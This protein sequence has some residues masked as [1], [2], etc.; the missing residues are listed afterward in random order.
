METKE[1]TVYKNETGENQPI[2]RDIY[3]PADKL[4]DL[5]SFAGDSSETPHPLQHVKLEVR[6]DTITAY[7]TNGHMAIRTTLPEKDINYPKMGD[8]FTKGDRMDIAISDCTVMYEF[9]KNTIKLKSKSVL[10]ELVTVSHLKLSTKEGLTLDVS[11][12]ANGMI[13]Q[14][15]ALDP[16]LII[17]AITTLIG[18]KKPKGISYPISMSVLD[19]LSPIHVTS[20]CRTGEGVDIVVMPMR[21]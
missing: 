9:L 20:T 15:F 19:N 10:F 18:T 8:I 5:V 6:G 17:Q 1:Y 16:K 11:C 7:S 12:E 21:V 14:N 4:A 2:E 13:E 3:I